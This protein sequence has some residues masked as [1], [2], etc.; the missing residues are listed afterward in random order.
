MLQ[1]CS[2]VQ[3]QLTWN[4]HSMTPPHGKHILLTPH[5]SGSLVRGNAGLMKTGVTLQQLLRWSRDIQESTVAANLACL[6]L[7]ES[8]AV[9]RITR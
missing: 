6:T 7:T 3:L 4:E 9:F 1:I 8:E 5:L 2:P